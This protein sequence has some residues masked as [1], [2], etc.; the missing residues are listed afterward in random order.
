VLTAADIE[1]SPGQSL[2]QLLLA[3]VPGLTLSRAPDGRVIL[4]LRGTT[5]FRGDE[6]PL[7]VVNDIPLGPNPSG[8]LSAIDL[9]DIESV[10]VLRDAAGTA[11]YG[12]RGANG[13]III[14]TK[15]S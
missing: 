1:R 2:E 11:A 8:N 15:Q 13:V 9:H 5:T 7:I 10:A 3:H 4:H 6:E 12:M 14:K